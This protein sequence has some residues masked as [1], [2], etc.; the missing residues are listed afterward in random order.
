MPAQ[1]IYHNPDDSQ[2]QFLDRNFPGL[3]DGLYEIDLELDVIGTGI[4][5]TPY[6]SSLQ[7]YIE[8]PQYSL[9]PNHVVTVYPPI[10]SRGQY[11]N[12]LPHLVLERSSLPWERSPNTDPESE[13]PWLF[14]LMLRDSEIETNPV[15]A[16]TAGDFYPNFNPGPGQASDDPMQV[17]TLDTTLA[18]AVLP[19]YADLPYIA[20]TRQ[21]ISASGEDLPLQAICLGNRVPYDS[22]RIKML[23]VS[24]EGFYPNNTLPDFTGLTSIQLPVLYQWNF[25]CT[26]VGDGGPNE[27]FTQLVQDLNHSPSTLRMP[28]VS[29]SSGPDPEPYLAAGKVPVP[30]QFRNGQQSVSWFR[31]PLATGEQDITL[32]LP[33]S[34][35]DAL[36]LYS[37][38]DAMFDI[39]YGSAWEMGRLLSLAQ[40]R[41][42]AALY[43]WKHRKA[44]ATKQ[45]QQAAADNHLPGITDFDVWNALLQREVANFP[46]FDLNQS[47]SSVTGVHENTGTLN[48][49]WQAIPDNTFGGCLAL[50]AS[51]S[52]FQVPSI[53]LSTQATFTLSFWFRH[54]Q[55]L[56]GEFVGLLGFESQNGLVSG[57]ITYSGNEFSLRTGDGNSVSTSSQPP[58]GEWQ[59]LA[60]E[61][62]WQGT[63]FQYTLYHNGSLLLTKNWAAATAPATGGELSVWLGKSYIGSEPTFQGEMGRLRVFDGQVAES[64]LPKVIS[65]DKQGE[66]L[67][68]FLNELRLVKGLPFNYLVPDESMLPQESFRVF[69]LDPNWVG[70]LLDG[71][72]SIGR[73]S[74][75]HLE[76]DAQYMEELGLA[77]YEGL[78]GI[79]IR[80]A[81]VAGWPDLQVEAYDAIL[82]TASPDPSTWLPCL[83]QEKLSDNTLIAIF[84]GNPQTFEIHL[85][86]TTQHYGVDTSN[87]TATFYQKQI[88]QADGSLSGA[89]TQENFRDSENQVIGL[90]DLAG[91]LASL[92]HTTANSAF[93]AMEM[94]EGVPNVRFTL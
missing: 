84:R 1:Y 38:A 53:E 48:G 34:N 25:N 89:S 22:S 61:V 56:A 9:S 6:Q 80:S 7:Y 27:S 54:E 36:Y 79:I 13:L 85:P 72:F 33:A 67:Y 19:S 14:L 45:A 2:V 70:C 24:L 43:Q 39:S 60:L 91:G 15:S 18:A 3:T 29:I 83:R 47:G 41:F 50:Q 76:Q 62:A 35:P 58:V 75:G 92:A 21:G 93:F 4:S 68:P 77:P 94:I 65:L 44:V 59:H 37:T 74:G 5:Q 11:S 52:Y 78:S 20:H 66:Q 26:Q 17:V 12:F 23:L 51:G 40:Q 16:T 73:S 31:S 81:A 87:L 30:H 8:G 10:E 57:D 90:S 42:S 49:T 32:P 69:K 86:T 63:Q 64:Q 88:R 71:A 46:L 82:N 28:A 55:D